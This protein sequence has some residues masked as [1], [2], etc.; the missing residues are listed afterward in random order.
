MAGINAVERKIRGKVF[1]QPDKRLGK[2]DWGA[3]NCKEV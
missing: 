1:P 3:V 2:G